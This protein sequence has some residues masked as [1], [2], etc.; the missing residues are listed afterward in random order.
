MLAW[1][2]VSCGPV[3]ATPVLGLTPGP[4]L[5]DTQASQGLERARGACVSPRPLTILRVKMGGGESDNSDGV[6][7]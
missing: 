2:S 5:T 1:V 4:Q 6:P 7:S 3:T